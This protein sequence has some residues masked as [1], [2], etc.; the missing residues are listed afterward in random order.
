[1][2]EGTMKSRIMHA[3]TAGLLIAML[4]IAGGAGY[5]LPGTRAVL[6]IVGG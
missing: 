5:A 3:I 2:K 4:L 6:R 1:M